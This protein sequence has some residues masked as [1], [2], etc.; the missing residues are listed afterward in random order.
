MFR[1]LY[2]QSRRFRD[3]NL[4][5]MFDQVE[6]VPASYLAEVIGT[7]YDSEEPDPYFTQTV[8]YSLRVEAARAYL[9]TV[10]LSLTP[11][12]FLLSK[13]FQFLY[14]PL[15]IQDQ[16]DAPDALPLR[17]RLEHWL[18]GLPES[19]VLR[20]Y[21]FDWLAFFEDSNRLD[22]PTLLAR[23]DDYLPGTRRH[24]RRTPAMGRRG[25]VPN[26]A[27]YKAV[28]KAIRI[29]GEVWTRRPGL[30]RVAEHLDRLDAP[31][32]ENWARLD[33]PA[34]SW[35]SAVEAHPKRVVKILK[36]RLKQLAKMRR[37]F[38]DLKPANPA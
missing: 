28:A 32:P 19:L 18:D 27:E 26:L 5:T 13:L 36:Y 31:S 23:L 33:P 16:L 9:H 2:F 38:Q 14:V 24:H 17:R 30:R 12:D 35:Q 37:R 25:P 8:E 15:Q 1:N 11:R 6:A 7:A 3:F 20:L 21:R 4:N 34:T 10:K 22:R 29:V